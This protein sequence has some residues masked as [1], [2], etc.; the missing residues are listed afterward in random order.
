HM[1]REIAKELGY[2]DDN[3]EQDVL[4]RVKKSEENE[5]GLVTHYEKAL[6]EKDVLNACYA[7]SMLLVDKGYSMSLL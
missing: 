3:L 4:L 6:R 1:S 7:L 5:E 2:A